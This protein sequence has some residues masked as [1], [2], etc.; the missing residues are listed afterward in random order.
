MKMPKIVVVG[1]GSSG[2]IAA[3]TLLGVPGAEVTVIESPNTPIIGVGES[4]IDGFIDWMNLVGI[5]P[6]EMMK[7]TDA[8]YK[9][10]IKFEDFLEPGHSFYYPFGTQGI[11]KK[12]YENWEKRRIV[13]PE[14]HKSFVDTFC[15]NMALVRHNKMKKDSK[16]FN[17]NC[18]ALHFDASKFGPWL[19]EKYCKPRGVTHIQMEV[20]D[21]KVGDIGIEWIVLSNGEKVT[22]DLF[23]D[24]TGF[25]SMLLEGA[26]QVPFKDYSNV[27]PNNMAWSTHLPYIDKEKELTGLTTCTTLENGW[28]WNIP[29]WSRIGAGYVYSKKFVTDDEA[30]DEFKNH[31]RKNGRDPES[32]SYKKISMK[33]GIHEKIWH[34]NVV[35]IGL[36]AGFIEPLESTGLWFTHQFAYMLLRIL[37]RGALPSQHDRDMFNKTCQM[38]WDKTVYFVALHYALSARR[39]TKYWRSIGDTSFPLDE[40][41]LWDSCQVEE[42]FGG[43]WP[44]LNCIVHGLEYHF[45]DETYYWTRA[46]PKNANWKEFFKQEFIGLDYDYKMWEIEVETAPRLIDVLEK[47]HSSKTSP[48]L[49]SLP[50]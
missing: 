31:I 46:F 29:L 14:E 27:I 12:K 50:E 23:I 4:T 16:T 39:D 25:K 3:T 19:R 33:N 48:V 6:E 40:K 11:D 36:A 13:C 35:A 34:K 42:R 10:A 38:Q 44:G 30:L 22:A 41:F 28:A 5:S 45:F 26:L 37:Y 32:L 15:P 49:P 47:I 20:T 7:D 8:S 43:N 9:L 24:C 17:H 2:W 18:H 21:I 1:G